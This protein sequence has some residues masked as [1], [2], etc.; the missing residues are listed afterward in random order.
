[1][2][3]SQTFSKHSLQ[4]FGDLSCQSDF[5]Q[6]IQHLF[7]LLQGLLYQVNVDFRLS[8]GSD[9][10]K[11]TDIL[12]L[13]ILK[14]SR[15]S[16]L[17]G[18]VQSIEF[19]RSDIGLIE[20]TDFLIINFED[21]FVHQSIENS[22]GSP[23]LFQ[24]FLLGNFLQVFTSA[25]PTRKFHIFHQYGQ[26]FLGS[27]KFIEQCHHSSV[28]QFAIDQSHTGFCPRLVT[29]F[30]IFFHEDSLLLQQSLHDGKD[31]LQANGSLQLGDTLFLVRTKQVQQALFILRK[32]LS[33]FELFIVHHHGFALQLHPRRHSCLIDITHC[34]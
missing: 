25:C 32:R 15:E 1:M 17:L 19:K 33:S 5:R 24:Q 13:E 22:R 21:A 34:T 16:P 28:I 31:I 3:Y 9:T 7:A 12:L 26:L 18:R 29:S 10:M 6:Q 30:Q 20:S 27:G 4:T 8:T 14:D 2:I 11:K 23:R